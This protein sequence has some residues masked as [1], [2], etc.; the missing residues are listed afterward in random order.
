MYLDRQVCVFVGVW[1]SSLTMSQGSSRYRKLQILSGAPK[2]REAPIHQGPKG[3]VFSVEE[4]M[5][6]CCSGGRALAGRDGEGPWPIIFPLLLGFRKHMPLQKQGHYTCILQEA[7]KWEQEG[8]PQR[9]QR[10]F[11]P[12]PFGCSGETLQLP[13]LVTP[14]PLLV[15]QWQNS[16]SLM[17]CLTHQP[18]HTY[19]VTKPIAVLLTSPGPCFPPSLK[20]QGSVALWKYAFN[21]FFIKAA[22]S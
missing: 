9:V 12:E 4:V 6:E 20:M 21:S 7:G 22:V 18:A 16:D 11:P 13:P 1:I 3:G 8:L 5:T 10:L 17:E 15:R 2:F 14:E 19:P